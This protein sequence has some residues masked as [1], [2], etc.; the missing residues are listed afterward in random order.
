[1]HGHAE[2]RYQQWRQPA[3]D[4]IG[5]GALRPAYRGIAFG[6]LDVLYAAR[7]KEIESQ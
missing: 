7:N 6:T 4:R 5:L 3:V 2:R 1:M